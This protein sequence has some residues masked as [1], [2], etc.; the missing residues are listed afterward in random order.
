[1]HSTQMKFYCLLVDLQG[2]FLFESYFHTNYSCNLIDYNRYDKYSYNYQFCQYL[3]L[4]LIDE[5][6]DE[7]SKIKPLMDLKRIDDI[8]KNS[9]GV[10]KYSQ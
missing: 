2:I 1:M 3:N 9:G 10:F 8:V 7:L 4:Q 6:D 5:L